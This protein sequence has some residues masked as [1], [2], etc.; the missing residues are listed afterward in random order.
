MSEPILAVQPVGTK[1][2]IHLTR[3]GYLPATSG[4]RPKQRTDP[5]RR[6][7]CALYVHHEAPVVSLV[8]AV[9][10]PGK[11]VGP[12]LPTWRWCA[13]CI[14]RALADAG[15]LDAAIGVLTPSRIA[16]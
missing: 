4:K 2:L 15:Q 6:T 16:D 7:M 13:V 9:T 8:E 12:L 5:D 11:R 3:A 14:G 1:A 10:W